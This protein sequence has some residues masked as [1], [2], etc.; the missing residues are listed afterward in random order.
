MDFILVPDALTAS[1][2]RYAL[3]QRNTMGTKV[4]SFSVLLETLAELWLIEPSELDWGAALQE[5][6]LAMGDAFWARS[7]RVDERF[8]SVSGMTDYNIF[9]ILELESA[10]NRLRSTFNPAYQLGLTG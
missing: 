10:S 6:A 4:G 3:A 1:E 5:Q 2:T 7:I 9:D 8:K